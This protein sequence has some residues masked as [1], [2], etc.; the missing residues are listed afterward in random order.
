MAPADVRVPNGFTILRIA[1]VPGAR[2]LVGLSNGDVIAGTKADDVVLVRRAEDAA[3]DDPVV[4]AHLPESPA[5]GVA[6]SPSHRTLYVAT[7]YAVYVSNYA[8]GSSTASP[9][10]VIAR[11]RTGPI[12]PNSDGDV[13][14]TTSLAFDETTNTL[15]VA[16][17]SSCNACTEADPTRA[18]I[19]A[20]QPDGSGMHKIATRIR[21][22]I[23][24]AIDPRT[25]ALWAG[26]AGQDDL[27]FGHPYEFLDDVSAHR[28]VADYGW[29]DCEENHRA[30]VA[31]ARCDDTVEPL[32]EI[33][34][35]STFIGA[36]FYPE[37]QRG[38]Y[39]FPARY[40]G[41]VFAA[42]HGSWHRSPDG[43]FTAQPRVLF[44]AMRGDRPAKPVTWND[45]NTQWETFVGGF[46]QGT[47]R[48]GRPTG[49]AVG[50]RGSLFVAD[51][52]AG[53]IYRIRPQR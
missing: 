12:A 7:E 53:A 30:Y 2:E 27:P 49:V 35:Y 50:A 17:G 31:G 37:N 8:P 44:V 18:S 13:H 48:A 36:T 21:N 24:L 28:A 9:P 47:E 41:G 51:D 45:P 33:P 34:A 39:A 46:Q 20:M 22:A 29:P 10:R 25:H 43:S 3:P 23:A 32:V 11:V 5:A 1:N 19:F 40:W 16:V 42:A 15:Y 52:D 14:H 38:R 4:V 26:D 6:F